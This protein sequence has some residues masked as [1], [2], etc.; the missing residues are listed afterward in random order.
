MRIALFSW[1]LSGVLSLI[2]AGPGAAYEIEGRQMFGDGKGTVLRVISTTDIEILGPLVERFQAETPGVSVDYV[3]ASST[4]LMKAIAEEGEH[5]DVALSS[6][7][8]LQ[9]KLAND[10]FTVAH[11]GNARVNVPQWGRWRDHVLAFSLEPASFV[12]NRAA[13]AGLEIPRTRQALVTLL[14][15]QPNRFRG[16]IATYDV[17]KS[18]LGFLF[19]T[20]D[21]RSSDTYW[22]LLEVM[23]GLGVRLFC[24][25]AEMIEAVARGDVVVAYNVLG[26]YARARTDLA[27]Q[28]E[29]IDPQDFTHTM[30]RTAVILKTSEQKDLAG[31]FVDFLLSAAWGT[32]RIP[33]FPFRE[34]M[35]RSTENAH[36]R[37]IH[38]GP[39]LL[40][41]LDHQKRARFLREWNNAVRQK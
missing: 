22:R 25:S 7:M 39:G 6:A 20:Q 28:I 41:F 1:V 16:K 18:G 34:A 29:V 4:E 14:R 27:D 17:E 31:G 37:P 24:C 30:M 13:F 26:T 23:G 8:D 5:F 9:T 40:V 38:L 15:N 32:R 19:A 35:R 12:V 33:E 10:G 2:W 11:D 21:A 36:V 3:A